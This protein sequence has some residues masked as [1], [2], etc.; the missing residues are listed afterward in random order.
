M[1]AQLFNTVLAIS[2]G[3]LDPASGAMGVAMLVATTASIRLGM[4]SGVVAEDA[5]ELM[6][7]LVVAKATDDKGSPQLGLYL[8]EEPLTMAP[9]L[10]PVWLS[11]P[12]WGG[13]ASA[14]LDLEEHLEVLPVISSGSIPPIVPLDYRR[15]SNAHLLFQS[16]SPNALS[17]PPTVEHPLLLLIPFLIWP[18]PEN[19][20]APFYPGL[21][22]DQYIPH[23]WTPDPNQAFYTP[24]ISQEI[25]PGW[26]H[27]PA[28]PANGNNP[29][30][31]PGKYSTA[32]P[33][34]AYLPP[35]HYYAYLAPL[36]HIDNYSPPCLPFSTQVPPSPMQQRVEAYA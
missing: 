31:Y 16:P 11:P 1:S 22:V 8:W 20:Y 30:M 3:P 5:P 21:P 18:V 12:P 24:S 29:H 19:P 2:L 26:H 25:P 23:H 34:F 6:A 27:P 35:T 9:L 15:Y 14:L 36:E 4:T 32:L 10:M 17:K 33:N 28:F 13:V 7:G